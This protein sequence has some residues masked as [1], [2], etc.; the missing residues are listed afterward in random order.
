MR[1]KKTIDEDVRSS[2]NILH[3]ETVKKEMSFSILRVVGLSQI[4]IGHLHAK[5]VKSTLSADFFADLLTS[6]SK[7]QLTS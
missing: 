3:F 4:V 6:S 2:Y 5:S 7:L 1:I